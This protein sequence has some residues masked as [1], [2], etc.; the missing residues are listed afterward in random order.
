MG[1]TRT[2][3]ESAEKRY[4]DWIKGQPGMSSYEF[5]F[6]DQDH[7]RVFIL[8]NGM[9]PETKSAIREKLE[10]LMPVEFFEIG[11]ITAQA[12]AAG[13]NDP[14]SRYGRDGCATPAKREK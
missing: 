4:G 3:V 7:S 10:G 2:E 11:P 5:Q 12:A 9:T 14:S 6:I 1:L 8:T 13:P